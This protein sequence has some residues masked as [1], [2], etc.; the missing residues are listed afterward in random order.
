MSEE[1]VNFKEAMTQLRLTEPELNEIVASGGLR[2]FR[3]RD[4]VKFRSEDIINLKKSRETEP[5]IVLS[6]T[7][8]ERLAGAT[9]E[10]PIDLD[11]ISSDDTVLNI[12]GL[13]EDDS[14]GTTPIP[15]AGILEGEEEI[16]IGGVGEDTVL[17]TE[18][19]DL[20]EDLDLMEDETV[21][22]EDGS[23][24]VGGGGA[25]TVQMVK[26][27]SHAGL[28]AALAATLVV[29]LGPTAIL[30]NLAGDSYP[31]WI[32]NGFLT[33]FNPIVESILGIF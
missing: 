20:G 27:D 31:S 22:T 23:T 6:D 9:D 12:E 32:S 13:L 24:L 19:L 33:L 29:L 26:K 17:D 16:E 10:E 28:T 30:L 1:F 15:G 7:Q 2:A 4:E 21:L 14:E 18:G 8:A 5:T 3:E 11:S 25:R